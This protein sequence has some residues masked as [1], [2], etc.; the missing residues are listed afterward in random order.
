MADRYRQVSPSEFFYNNR[1][2]AGFGN[3]SAAIYTA[4]RELFENALDACDTTQT[5]TEIHMD[6]TNDGENYTIMVRDNGPGIP[7]DRIPQVFGTIMF[8]SKFGLKQARGMF[9]MGATMA[10]LYGQI[11]SGI[12]FKVS[13]GTGKRW[14]VITMSIDIKNNKPRILEKH[15]KI[16]D[17]PGTEV[18][19]TLRGNYKNSGA[20][21]RR[22]I[23]RTGLITPY[24]RISYNGPKGDTILVER[25]TNIMP[26][27][28]TY[29]T[30]HPR[31]VDAETIRRMIIHS[32]P[33]ISFDDGIISG[34]RWKGSISG[35]IGSILGST[36]EMAGG[37][38]LSMD[39]STRRILW[40]DTNGKHHDDII[41]KT[42][43][44]LIL[45]HSEKLGRMLTRFDGIGD[46][47]A[48]TFCDSVGM[49]AD[50]PVWGLA[51]GDIIRLV[52]AMARYT[53]WRSPDHT[54]LAPLGADLLR[55]GMLAIFEPAYVD[56]IQRRPISYGGWPCIIEMGV[57]YG[58]KT[59]PG[60]YR[61]ANRIPLLYGE[62]ADAT[63]Q[64]ITGVD[65][66]RYNIKLGEDPVAV[67]VHVCST[68]VPYKSVGKE[69]IASR[70]EINREVQLGVYDLGKRLSTYIRH[71]HSREAGRKR[72]KIL[73]KY[74]YI[75][76][77]HASRLAGQK[78]PDIGSIS[79]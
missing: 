63:Y 21:I 5:P 60:I 37:R 10:I 11:T 75:T 8:G 62:G 72:Q 51:D 68:R 71:K 76:L 54:C 77:Q 45:K 4:V 27:P 79:S 15:T 50:I 22:Y 13:S 70:P 36:H 78:P 17:A 52:D 39:L 64:T 18:A 65:W 61:F 35:T 47:R 53:R 12:P 55:E 31:G 25:A 26:A 6:I 33:D 30:P 7:A 66:K 40:E 44:K 38:I 67:C 24:A 74:L 23:R 59:T 58:G 14:T 46:I 57:S 29:T 69:S 41:N 1:D 19:V 28:P 73:D 3:P 20:Y 56:A 42:K 34:T 48:K 43:T 2:M 32:I 9:G 16:Q 49:S